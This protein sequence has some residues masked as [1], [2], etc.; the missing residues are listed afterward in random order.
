MAFRIFFSVNY[1]F[2]QWLQ[3]LLNQLIQCALE[4]ALDLILAEGCLVRHDS[5]IFSPHSDL[6]DISLLVSRSCFAFGSR[7]A[8][9]PF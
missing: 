5:E 3:T 6:F 7:S 1:V 9:R 8:L 4:A 2:L